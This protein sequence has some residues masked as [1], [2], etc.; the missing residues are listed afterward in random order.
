MFAIIFKCF[1]GV[2]AT[3]SDIYFKCFICLL[4]YVIIITYECFKIR[5]GVAH[6]MH[7]E[8]AD[9]AC[10]VRSSVGPLLGCSLA[11][12]THWGACSLTERVPSDANT[13]DQTS[14]R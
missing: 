5:P 10:N 6:G 13:L 8:A 1:S 14:G 4:L 3:V 2:F 7:G 9:S 12:S 11:S